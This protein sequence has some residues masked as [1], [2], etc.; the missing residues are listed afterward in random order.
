VV[1]FL[2][3]G[4]DLPEVP[5]GPI[6]GGALIRADVNVGISGHA[7]VSHSSDHLTL[8][9]GLHRQSPSDL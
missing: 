6:R 3:Q 5:T 7:V 9:N 4:A 8:A 2:G 1:P